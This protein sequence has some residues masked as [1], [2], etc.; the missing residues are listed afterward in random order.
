[1]HS[2]D[3]ADIMTSIS[4]VIMI[5]TAVT[6]ACSM[7]TRDVITDAMINTAVIATSTVTGETATSG[8]ECLETGM[9]ANAV[10]GTEHSG[11]H[12]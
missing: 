7:D 5:A 3:T 6:V 12:E 10:I 9:I 11:R 8:P 4:A 1:M 2:R